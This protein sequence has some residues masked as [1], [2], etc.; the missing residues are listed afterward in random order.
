MGAPEALGV[1]CR[2]RVDHDLRLAKIAARRLVADAAIA[3][4][5]E[6]QHEVR[7]GGSAGGEMAARMR[8]LRRAGELLVEAHLAAVHVVG[9]GHRAIGGDGR[10]ELRDQHARRVACVAR[11]FEGDPRD[12]ADQAAACAERPRVAAHHARRAREGATLVQRLREPV[13]RER[14]R[15]LRELRAIDRHATSQRSVRS[16]PAVHVEERARDAAPRKFNPVNVINLSKLP[17]GDFMTL[18]HGRI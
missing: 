11:V 16:L 8:K 4:V 2:H 9:V 7:A 3:E 10:R 13:R 5:L 1:K 6:Q 14:F 15:A 18:D 17:G 12:D